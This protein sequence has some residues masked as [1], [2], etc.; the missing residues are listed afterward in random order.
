MDGKKQGE[1]T[2]RSLNPL[3]LLRFRPGGVQ[4]ELIVCRSPDG[5]SK[6]FS[7]SD[8]FFFSSLRVRTWKNL[9]L[10]TKVLHKTLHIS[11]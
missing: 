7:H 11:S 10:F 6:Y 5:K 4:E 9:R 3:P 1:Q 2:Y 8:K